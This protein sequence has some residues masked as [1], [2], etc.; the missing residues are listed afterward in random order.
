[1]VKSMASNE[2]TS[3]DVAKLAAIKWGATVPREQKV[4]FLAEKIRIGRERG[5]SP[6]WAA[7]QFSLRHGTWP[8]QSEV[9]EANRK[10]EEVSVE[11]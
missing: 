5:Y 11:W 10:K 6:K 2:K 7:V 8:T 1:M 4:A 3:V 9:A